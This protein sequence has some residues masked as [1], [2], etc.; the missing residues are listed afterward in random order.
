MGGKRHILE[1]IINREI[2]H[3]KDIELLDIELLHV[4]AEE[5]LW[6]TQGEHIYDAG[7]CIY[8]GR[9]LL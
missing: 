9:V 4:N 5:P 6:G 3:R 2:L 7:Q 1:I 8:R